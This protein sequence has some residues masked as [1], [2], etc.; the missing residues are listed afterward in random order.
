MK[1]LLGVTLAVTLMFPTGANAP[2]SIG[3]DATPAC[4][5]PVVVSPS[6]G[7]PAASQPP[8]AAPASAATDISAGRW[9][10]MARAPFGI[11]TD[12]AAWTGSMM[13]VTRWDDGRSASYDPM[14]DR[15]QEVAQAP[16]GFRSIAR[17]VWTGSEFIILEVDDDGSGR[18][19]AYDP[20]ADRWREIAP[21]PA[22]PDG[23]E[24]GVDL[25][26]WTGTHVLVL[27][28]SGDLSAYEPLAD[29]WLELPPMPGD[30]SASGLYQVGSRLLVESRDWAADSVSMR[31]FDPATG[32]WSDPVPGPLA[33]L[34]AENGG[35]VIGDRVVYVSWIKT[36]DEVTGVWDAVFD[37]ATMSWSTFD[38]KCR[39]LAF[40]PSIVAEDTI[41][42]N[43][44]RR[45]LDGTTLACFDMP[46]P[47][48]RFN[49]TEILVWM[50]SKLIVWSGYREGPPPPRRG[51]FVYELRP[52]GLPTDR[53]D[54][55]GSAG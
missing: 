48:R 5:P 8:D 45:A 18:G 20:A 10:R 12:L 39:T 54:T 26:V 51:G 47:P 38:H 40:R 37:P 3:A 55:S 49:G 23:E 6:G 28:W 24:H 31:T 27:D 22:E 7:S 25:P 33:S 21:Y 19:L 53:T 16:R 30:D 2:D 41:I 13:I 17:P 14:H 35:S 29:C 9:H 34:A 36:D 42:A 4:P 50:G 52:D 44:A 11:A 1:P 43:D 15:W 46:K 32:A